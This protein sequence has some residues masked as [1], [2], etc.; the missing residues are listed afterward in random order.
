LESVLPWKPKNEKAAEDSK[1]SG[2]IIFTQVNGAPL[3]GFL[4]YAVNRLQL[5]KK[6]EHLRK[7][8]FYNVLRDIMVFQNLSQAME[9]RNSAI[10]Q[11]K[12]CPTIITVDD[13]EMI[14]SSG[15]VTIGTYQKRL[16]TINESDRMIIRWCKI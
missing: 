2:E 4:G 13:K 5:R 3:A 10:K 1:A 15:F 9:Y 16:E 7:S 14:E 6:H 11:G 8:L 12:P